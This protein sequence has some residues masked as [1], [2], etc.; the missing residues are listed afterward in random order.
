MWI[1]FRCT[2]LQWQAVSLGSLIVRRAVNEVVSVI[3]R[4][5]QIRS[6]HCA[7]LYS[8]DITAAVRYVAG[9]KLLQFRQS[10]DIHGRMADMTDDMKPTIVSNTEMS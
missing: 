10:S 5:T 6:K 2:C 7:R 8:G 9:A 4:L 3:N 1:V